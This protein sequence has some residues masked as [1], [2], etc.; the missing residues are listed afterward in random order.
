MS[1]GAK[2]PYRQVYPLACKL[3]ERLA[4]ACARIEIAGSLRRKESHVGD[5]ELVAIPK[6][7]R[8]VMGVTASERWGWSELDHLLTDWD[9]DERIDI[10][11]G[12]KLRGKERKYTKF[13][14]KSSAGQ[15]YTV[16]LFLQ[17]D[18]A[19]WGVNLMIRT[20]SQAFSHLMVTPKA[21]GGFAP[22]DIKVEGALVWRNG[23]VVPTPEEQ[24]IFELWSLA[25]VAPEKR[26]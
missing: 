1:L 17:P 25:Y 15:T 23:A 3:I 4:P 26:R 11:T 12:G 20:G 13:L 22:N 8:P 5:I 10:V 18:P 24:D 16:D 2:L 7:E 6:F 14:F 19:T 21:F 9:R